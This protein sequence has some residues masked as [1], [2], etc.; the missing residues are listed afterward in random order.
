MPVT[1]LRTSDTDR[2]LARMIRKKYPA[3][4]EKLRQRDMIFS[5]ISKKSF[6]LTPLTVKSEK[7]YIY[8]IFTCS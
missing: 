1:E 4:A 6:S 2:K 8:I 5:D 3:A 7:I